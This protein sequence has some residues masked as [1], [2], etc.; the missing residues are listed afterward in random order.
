MVKN[1]I[2]STFFCVGAVLLFAMMS[3]VFTPKRLPYIKDNDGGK[4]LCFLGEKENSIDVLICGTSHAARGILPMELY[5]SYGIKAYNLSSPAQPIEAT[6]YILKEALK[7]QKPVLFIYDVSSLYF[8]RDESYWR[9]VL[10]EMP[11]G[12]N[13]ILLAKECVKEG[14]NV[15][16]SVTELT[17]P[18]LGYH[19]RWAQLM[20]DDFAIFHRNRRHFGK[21]G[22]L[23]STVVGGDISAETM[24]WI[25]GQLL[26]DTE[27]V[28]SG[29]REGGGYEEREVNTAYN[30]T[31]PEDKFSWLLKIKQLCEENNIQFL[32]I[33][34]P[35][36]YYPQ[37]YDAT[38]VE[39]KYRRLRA[40]CDEY[41]IAYYDLQYETDLKLDM[42]KD[43]HDGGMHLN[44][45]GAQKVCTDLGYYL[46]KHY[47][48][49]GENDE[50]WDRDLLLYEGQ[51]K[52]A[53]LQMEQ[54]L[55]A[56]VTTLANEYKDR[57]IFIVAS[58]MLQGL[59][60]NEIAV[61]QK[62]GLQMF[63]A[64]DFRDAYVAVIENGNV[65]Y[66]ALSNRQ[67]DYEGI[68][69][70]EESKL[71]LHSSGWKTSSHT[72]IMISDREYTCGNR[73]IQIV[74]YD[75]KRDLVLD[76]VCF[77]TFLEDHKAMR[78]NH[79]I[80]NLMEEVERYLIENEQK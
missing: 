18:F 60:R 80:N 45:N 21:G 22:T 50:Q 20:E 52:I 38:W 71:S 78:D 69:G 48:L 25:A 4:I 54:D 67:L 58:D 72:S 10:D 79:L 13:R 61:F 63:S 66:E 56:Y 55:S 36:T 49:P 33:K 57:S 14:E 77:D 64:D 30:V 1:L 39:E 74:V 24:N 44:L 41:G 8:D 9:Y 75:N 29:F 73:G 19:T 23:V 11:L 35:V 3:A 7:S 68:C 43:S 37:V 42:E 46:E 2:K 62:L 53:Q 51:R 16:S 12:E 28:E 76:S 31:A 17:V 47:D 40:L 5:E 15:T 6:Y 32:A 34:I 65:K 70:Q 27:L 59:S 26:Q